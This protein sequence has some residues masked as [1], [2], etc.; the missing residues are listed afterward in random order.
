MGKPIE[1]AK[2]LLVEGRDEEEFFGALLARPGLVDIDVRAMEGKSRLADRLKVLVK[3]PSAVPIQSVGIVQDGDND[4]RAAFQSIGAALA[5]AGLPA[6]DAPQ[7]PQGHD[8]R[9]TV[10]I[11]PDGIRP[12][13]LEDLCL[14]AVRSDPALACVDEFFV[15]LEESASSVSQNPAKA[16]VRS[17]LAG[18]EWQEE[19]LFEALQGQFQASPA[20]EPAISKLHA[21]L[22][23][24][25]KPDLRLGTAA[26]AGYWPLDDVVF[27]PLVDFLRML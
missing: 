12:G 8:P 14:A 18:M 7:R 23:T 24:R 16:R 1:K 9:I 20:A 21:F 27:Q 22:A 15:C 19:R 5:A 2:L 10:M 6:P 26:Q 11:L 4:P 17:F 13:M 3:G 25:Y